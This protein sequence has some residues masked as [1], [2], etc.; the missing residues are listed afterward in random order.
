MFPGYYYER[1][2]GNGKKIFVAPLTY[3]RARMSV[4]DDYFLD[5][6]Y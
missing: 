3:G 1:D 6:G 5:D 4:G 2:L